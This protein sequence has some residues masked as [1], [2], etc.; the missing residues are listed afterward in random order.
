MR[1]VGKSTA[2]ISVMLVICNYSVIGQRH[3]IFFSNPVTLFFPKKYFITISINTTNPPSQIKEKA[4]NPTFILN[5]AVNR[6][7]IRSISSSP[8]LEFEFPAFFTSLMGHVAWNIKMRDFIG[9]G[10]FVFH[11][12]QLYV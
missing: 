2:N 12:H 3:L 10:F 5:P 11:S 4:K 7:F 9:K 6:L 8:Q 1:R